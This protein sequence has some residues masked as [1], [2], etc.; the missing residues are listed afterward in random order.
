MTSETARRRFQETV[1]PFLD[2][3]YSLAKW[4]S[5]DRAEAEDI[6]QDAAIRALAALERASVER[7]RA[8]FLRSSA[9]RR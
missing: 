5:G 9:T 3:A 4:L 8:W 6:V 2:D 7:P 1:P